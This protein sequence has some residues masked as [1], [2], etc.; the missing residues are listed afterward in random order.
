QPS[1]KLPLICAL[2]GLALAMAG[3]AQ[4][5]TTYADQILPLVENHCGKCHNP[6][7]RKGDLDL[8]T[9]AGVLKG[10]GSGAVVVAG[11]PDSSKLWKA[12]TQVEEPTMPPNK[13]PLPDQELALFKKWIAGGLL[14]NSGSKAVAASK[15]GVDLSVQI[16]S[17]GK[18]EGPPPM[19]GELPL[20]VVVH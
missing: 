7:K 4:D 2:P 14:E 19:P 12:I 13:P 3:S 16:S 20:E 11:H 18:P 1:M 6:D 5:K 17:V 8:T 10:G 15:P 9:Y